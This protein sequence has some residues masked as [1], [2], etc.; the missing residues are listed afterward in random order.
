MWK[1]TQVS[2]TNNFIDYV[3]RLLEVSFSLTVT[4]YNYCVSA[5]GGWR[6]GEFSNCHGTCGDAIKSR[7]KYCDN[8][9]PSHRWVKDSTG[10][11][12]RHRT[13]EKCPCYSTDPSCD[14]LKATV[15]RPCNDELCKLTKYLGL[16][17][18]QN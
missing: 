11:L 2:V 12:I 4:K 14:G 5:P 17:R 7:Y 1:R 13:G 15:Y 16:S 9:E 8:P 3:K 6:E 18:I 10:T